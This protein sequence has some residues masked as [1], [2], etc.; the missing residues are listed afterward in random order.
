[1]AA[2]TKPASALALPAAALLFFLS[3][4]TAL[5]AEVVLNKLLTYVFGASHLSTSTVLAAYMAGLSAGAY[6][7]GRRSARL[8]RPLLAYAT[9]ELGVGAFYALL[10]LL[11]AP[12]QRLGVAAAAPLAGTPALLTAVRFALSFLLVFAPTLMMGG[13]LPTMIAAFRGDQAFARS[14]PLL[15]AVNTLGAAAGVLLASYKLIPALG[16]DGA[17]YAC[18]AVN[19]AV[20]AA[21]ALLSRRLSPGA[22]SPAAEPPDEAQPLI[23]GAAWHLPPRAALALAF[24][25]GA[26]AFVLEVV[27]FHLI[28]TVIG[29]TT[30]AFALMLFAILL[31][32]GL[33]SLLL[34]AVLRLS[35]RPPA[36]IFAWAMLLAALGVAA[37]LRGWDEFATLVERTPEL[38]PAGHFFGRELA[39]LC[40][41]LTLL[42][43]TTLA[44]GM[45]LPAL[46]AAAAAGAG[47]QPGMWVGRLFAANTLGTITGSLSC[48][49]LLLGW[50]GSERILLLGAALALALALAALL[51]GRAA[52]D[53]PRPALRSAISR[54]ELGLLALGAA[55]AL[56]LAAPARWDPYRLTLGGHY[57][58]EPY[59]AKRES[60]VAWIREDSQSGFI[61]IMESPN[62][63]KTMRTNG[64]YEGNNARAEFQDLFALLGG[65]YLKRYERAVLVGLGPARTLNVLH[66]M[67]FRG[68]E[69]VEYSPAII[70]AAR[71][72]FAEFAGP[73]LA[74]TARV[75]LHCDDGRNHLQLSR[76]RYDYAAI[77]ISGAA[78]AG[79][80][81][82]YSRGFFEVVRARLAEGGVLMLWIQVHHVFP[83][84]VRSVVYTLRQVFPHVHLYTDPG[85]SQGFLL[86]SAAPLTIDAPRVRELDASPRIR[87]VLGLHGLGSVLELSER[88]AFTGDEELQRFLASPEVGPPPELLTDLRPAFEYATPYALAE[89]ISSF[90][91]QRFSDKRLPVFDPPLPDHELAAL[92]ARRFLAAGDRARA[93]AALQRAPPAAD[94]V[95]SPP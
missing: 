10:P 62:G 18:A 20:A 93:D 23:A 86:A 44:L 76:H 24:A 21:G 56:G 40:F 41:C 57:Y 66:A 13:T 68:I 59:E 15:Y 7:F 37:S 17:L 83:R 45:S 61:T 46:A 60:R 5:T 11:F 79:A 71:E 28:G 89:P 54:L 95:S 91:F 84:E 65:L 32:I 50:L 73:P 1:M 2:T 53:T 30:Y 19:L 90:D 16:L 12:F 38:R 39:R 77:A 27:W 8:R 51:A 4:A 67:P 94:A 14:L 9:L 6:V 87:E 81:N 64:K 85:Q 58:W 22:A 52:G 31:G 34:P 69:A 63:L 36:A 75:S 29:V 3:G 55:A 74:D 26:L 33:G 49:F 78:F 35:R 48:G 92:E 42:L 72:G 47:A 82:I 25:Q 88:G 70:A 43:P 80:G